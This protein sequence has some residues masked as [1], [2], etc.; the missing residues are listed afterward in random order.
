MK[1][2]TRYFV[3]VLMGIALASMPLWAQD[4]QRDG[5]LRI[6]GASF[7]SDVVN[8]WANAFMK[9]H[10]GVQVTVVGTSAGAG[11]QVFLD[12][13]SE[14]FLS[15][16][17]LSSE[18]AGKL[19]QAGIHVTGKQ[20]AHC[21]MV[22]ITSANNPVEQLSLD[23][24][25]KIFTGE[26]TN[27]KEVGGPDEPIRTLTR[28]IPESGA[29]IWFQQNVMKGAA[30]G[31]KTVFAERWA[32]IIKVCAEAKDFPIGIA[33]YSRDRRGTKAISLKKT[34]DATA[35][36]PDDATIASGT[37]P[38]SIPIYLYWDG[39]TKDKRILSFLNTVETHTSVAKSPTN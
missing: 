33:P 27:W 29:A 14:I 18:Q 6:Q 16:R 26:I 28:R 9:A 30:Y 34:A 20:V 10:P 19:T 24:V 36:A 32:T 25:S 35:T 1:S 39:Q 7:A 11:Y 38:L 15:T 4:G 2:A 22:V 5:P 12:K 17:E 37:Y 3:L 23:Q 31:P 8:V 13:Q 21:A